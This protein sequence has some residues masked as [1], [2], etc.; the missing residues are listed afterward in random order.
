MVRRLILSYRHN[1]VWTQQ[2]SYT[3]DST[4][5]LVTHAYVAADD[6]TP[7][8]HFNNEQSKRLVSVPQCKYNVHNYRLFAFFRIVNVQPTYQVRQH[9]VV[10]GI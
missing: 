7:I 9:S 1:Y 5:R 6:I 8:A 10:H 3:F 4:E 2:K